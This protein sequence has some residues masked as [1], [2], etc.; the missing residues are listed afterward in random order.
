M[1]VGVH[2]V[3][4]VSVC[5]NHDVGAGVLK[6]ASVRVGVEAS[7]GVCVGVCRIKC[8]CKRKRR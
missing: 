4:G 3:V 5:V 1:C 6:C 8:K 7:V 2:D